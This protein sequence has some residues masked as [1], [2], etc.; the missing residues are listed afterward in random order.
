MVSKAIMNVGLALCLILQEWAPC[1]CIF[2]HHLSPNVDG[3]CKHSCHERPASD[4]IDSPSSD[5]GIC[6]VLGQFYGLPWCGNELPANG[7]LAARLFE[8]DPAVEAK[9]LATLAA[10]RCDMIPLCDFYEMMML[11]E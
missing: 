4:P 1:C 10:C 8:H 7:M 2:Q 5:C 9:A 11:R 6:S 3:I